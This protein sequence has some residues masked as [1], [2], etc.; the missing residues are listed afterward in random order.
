MKIICML[1]TI[2]LLTIGH[3][4]AQSRVETPLINRNNFTEFNR[5]PTYEKEGV[6]LDAKSG[7]GILWLKDSL[8]GNGI[9]ELELKGKNI[10][11]RSF[12]GVAFHGK[13]STTYDAIYFRPFNF[14]NPERNGHSVQYISLPGNDWSTLREKFPG[15]YENRIE[16][17]P[18]P[19][20]DWFHARIVIDYPEIRVYVNHAAQP[21]LEVGQLNDMDE[22]KLG[23]WVGNGSDG[24]FRN[25]KITQGD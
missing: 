16:P 1:S 19:V 4:L 12:V 13:D 24:W 20:D 8:F 10:P 6:Y 11:G 15:K 18:D 2:L 14:R 22:G 9:I 5:K 21:T 25:L 17:L 23:F 7:S 3:L